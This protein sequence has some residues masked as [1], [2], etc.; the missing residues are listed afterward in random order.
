MTSSCRS[1]RRPPGL[2]HR[3][4]D[5]MPAINAIPAWSPPGPAC[6]PPPTCPSSR[7]EVSPVPDK[8]ASLLGVVQGPGQSLRARR[9]SSSARVLRSA[10]SSRAAGWAATGTPSMLLPHP[11]ACHCRSACPPQPRT[12]QSAGPAQRGPATAVR[13][14]RRPSGRWRHRDRPPARCC[15][16]G[17][18]RRRACRR[19]C[20]RP[21][22][23]R[24]P[25]CPPPPPGGRRPPRS[26]RAGDRP[27]ATRARPSSARQRDAPLSSA[28]ARADAELRPAAHRA[29]TAR[30]TQAPIA[31]ERSQARPSLSEIAC[32]G[33]PAREQVIER[34]DVDHRVLGAELVCG[35]ARRRPVVLPP[36]PVEQEP[37]AIG[38]PGLQARSG[39]RTPRPRVASGW[40]WS[41]T[42]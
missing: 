11:V 37:I 21:R 24:R 7:P 8:G 16:S 14:S 30:A 42:R 5:R 34:W 35:V 20:R 2:R 33:P 28:P 36:D 23:P 3:H 12:P 4:D 22:P 32:T 41:T 31:P 39:P 27:P 1:P 29:M 40:R 17:W 13:G 6:W 10:R 19:R 15:G 25:G 9:S 38:A 18:C 26:K